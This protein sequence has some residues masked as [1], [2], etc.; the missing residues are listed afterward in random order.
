MGDFTLDIPEVQLLIHY[1]ADPAGFF[2]H[3][4]ILLHRVEG[5]RWL[6]LTPDHEIQ[7]HDLQQERHRVLD[8]RAPFPPE[9]SHEIYAHDM[10]GK[11]QLLSFKRRARVQASIL[12]Q[13][14]LEDS[15]AFVWV[16]SQADHKSFGVEIDTN[17]LEDESLGL[18]FTSKGVVVLDGEEVF[19]ERVES[20]SLDDWRKTRLL[21]GGDSRLLGDHKDSAGKRRLDLG[22]AVEL[23]KQEPDTEFPIAGVRAAKELHEA[24]SEGPGNFLSYHAEWLRLSGVSKK[25]SAAHIH[26]SLSECLRLLHSYDQIDASSTA[27]GEHLSR[28]MIQTELAVERNPLSPDYGGLDIIAGSA[29]QADGRASTSKFN[30]W[31][32]SRLKERAQIWKQERLFAQEK[33]NLRGK[34]G[35]GKGHDSD[36]DEDPGKKNPKWQNKKK[37]KET[38]GGGG[39]G[40]RSDT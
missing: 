21:E 39:K 29:V 3:H 26:G 37:K 4:R 17:L 34:K 40:S 28:W 16:I 15:E 24:V 2:W 30:E 6:A 9:I 35:G 33:K 19:V 10:I 13:G 27:I 22:S 5:A 31:M 14:D 7:Q 32:S 1:G 38:D 36:S 20:R 12:G 18:A 23:M 8:R 25:S 11:A